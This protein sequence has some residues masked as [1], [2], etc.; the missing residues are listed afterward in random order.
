[1]MIYIYITDDYIC[2]FPGRVRVDMN[3]GIT[4]VN[5]QS[6]DAG[7]YECRPT[8]IIPAGG[9]RTPSNGTWTHLSVN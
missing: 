6:S 7:W 1:M 2:H 4:I 3:V 9:M 5:I 8:F